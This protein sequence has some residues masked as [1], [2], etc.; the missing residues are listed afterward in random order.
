ME[1]ITS[2]KSFIAMTTQLYTQVLE[3]KAHEYSVPFW[4]DSLLVNKIFVRGKPC[5]LSVLSVI[6]TPAILCWSLFD[7]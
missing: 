6:Y 5:I 4:N 1:N 3:M 2:A 7:Q